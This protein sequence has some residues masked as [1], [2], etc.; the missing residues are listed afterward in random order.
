MSILF[1][2]LQGATLGL[3]GAAMPGPFQAYLL[4]QTLRRGAR[5]TL[6]FSLAPLV[7]EVPIVG[8]ILLVVSRMPGW[9][10]STLHV[11]GGMLL[12]FLAVESLRAVRADARDE[13]A[14]PARNG[15]GGLPA[16]SARAGF[17]RAVAMNLL[18][19]GPYLFWSLLAGPVVVEAAGTSGAHA[20][21]FVLG[22]YG[23]L[24]G[25]FVAF[26]MAFGVAVRLGARVVRVLRVITAVGLLGFGF[27][28]IARGAGA[29]L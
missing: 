15:V 17:T 24:I 9:A 13:G 29:L 7:A 3:S 1:Y 19:P 23:L 4:D 12:L 11:A 28:Q 10:I 25:G 16:V 14:A 27:Y 21:G 5:G 20:A 18:S 22:F 2:L 6:P 26:V 8:V